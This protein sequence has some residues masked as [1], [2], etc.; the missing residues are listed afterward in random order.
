M[1]S[2]LD[3]D[4]ATPDADVADGGLPSESAVETSGNMKSNSSEQGGR[5]RPSNGKLVALWL[6]VAVL[7]VGLVLYVVEPM[8]QQRTQGML[9]DD[10]RASID[11]AAN[12]ATGLGG[13]EVSANAPEIGSPVGILEIGP[14]GLQQ[15]VIEGANSHA[16]QK[17]PGHVP[18]TAGPGQPGNSVVVGRSGMF[19][20]PFDGLSRLVPGDQFVV[21]TTQGQSLYE[22]ADVGSVTITDDP[23]AAGTS[24]PQVDSSLDGGSVSLASLYGTSTDD[25]LTLV[26]SASAF[27]WNTGEAEVVIAVMKGKPF[28]PTPQNGRSSHETGLT[29]DSTRWPLAMLT[30]LCLAA[31][32]VAAVFLY[33]RSSAKIAYLLTV[34]ALLAFA[35]VSS[36]S[37][38]LLL[39]AWT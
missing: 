15:V 23:A 18:G 11:Q 10:Y 12:Q 35:L 6:I 39:P 20:G 27:P 7:M 30:F 17:G 2:V 8:F 1:T 24:A 36:E 32:L 14:I 31:V 16:T 4:T 29:G 37:L 34:P 38:S 22:V 5:D 9:L 25:R 21:T 13:V 3:R 26:T 19:G 28:A 33:R